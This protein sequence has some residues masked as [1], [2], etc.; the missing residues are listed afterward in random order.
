M[1]IDYCT[2]QEIAYLDCLG[3]PF[4]VYTYI[5]AQWPSGIE[6]TPGDRVVMVSNPAGG[7]S[8]Q[9]FGNSVYYALPVSF[10]GDTKSCR[11]LLSGPYTRG[12]KKI[13][14]VCIGNV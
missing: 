7:T 8:L 3:I 4:V 11:S 6:R 14:P 1:W 10:G 9:K 2:H 12:S 5:G 13:Q